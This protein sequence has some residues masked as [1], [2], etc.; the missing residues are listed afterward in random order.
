MKYFSLF[1]FV[2]L[3][4]QLNAEP[5]NLD[6]I[7]DSNKYEISLEELDSLLVPANPEQLYDSTLIALQ[8]NFKISIA[9]N[10]QNQ[11]AELLLKMANYYHK[12]GYDYLSISK[13]NA[14]EIL[15]IENDLHNILINCYTQLSRVVLEGSNYS[16]SM[17]S[18][19][20]ALRVAEKEGIDDKKDIIYFGIAKIYVAARDYKNAIHF[21]NESIK[22]SDEYDNKLCKSEALL[23]LGK[24]LLAQNKME[25]AYQI[26][27]NSLVISKNSNDSISIYNCYTKLCNYYIENENFELAHKYCDSALLVTEDFSKLNSSRTSS[28]L[29][30]KAYVY[31]CQGDYEKTLTYN[32]LAFRERK[33]AGFL[34]HIC[35]SLNNLGTTYLKL[36]NFKK[37]DDFLHKALSFAMFMENN[38]FLLLVN[39]NL[40]QLYDTTNN[41]IEA[42][43]HYKEYHKYYSLIDE[44]QNENNIDLFKTQ[45]DLEKLTRSN[46]S[47]QLS[48]AKTLQ[49]SLLLISL[50]VVSLLI[51]LLLRLSAKQKHNKQLEK[52][53]KKILSQK[54]NL[55]LLVQKMMLAEEKFK[56]IITNIDSLML[57][58][59]KDGIVTFS[60]G[61]DIFHLKKNITE[62]VG[63]SMSDVFE[64]Y[65]EITK[66]LLDALSGKSSEEIIELKNEFFQVWYSPLIDEMGNIIGAISMI[67]DKTNKIVTLRKLKESE[68]RYKKV[69]DNIT[70]GILIVNQ[71][72]KIIDL[73]AQ[74]AEIYGG[75]KEEILG[76]SRIDVS[77]KGK[78]PRTEFRRIF[79]QALKTS[80]LD[81]DL[82]FVNKKNET[83]YTE[84]SA[85]T[86][87]LEDKELQLLIFIRDVS[88]RKNKERELEDHRKHLEEKV[89]YRTRALKEKSVGLEKSQEKLESLFIDLSITSKKLKNANRELQSFSYSV[90]H[91]LKAPLRAIDGFSQAI[92][93]E[94]F[95]Q[96]DSDGKEFIKLIRENTHKMG[97]LIQ[98]LL[99]FSRIGK[100]DLSMGKINM[101]EV[102]TKSFKE[103]F[104]EDFGKETKFVL[105]DLPIICADKKQ[106]IRVVENLLANAIKFTKKTENPEIV[107]DS[108]MTGKYIVFSVRDNGIGFDMKYAEKMFGVFQ[109]LH[110]PIDYDGTGVGLAIVKKII[111]KHNGKVWIEGK[112]NVGATVYFSI[113]INNC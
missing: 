108:K 36:K 91:D 84:C 17:E 59:D 12:L 47:L 99:E 93:E 54:E 9:Q 110:S 83:I 56:T 24:I 11:Q 3:I 70:D 45:Y 46:E 100:S 20:K 63:L 98:D 61:T 90:S 58:V 43:K 101:N 55:R 44:E 10:N 35:S 13:F 50:L 21:F 64:N 42:F 79:L 97:L 15:C 94:Y 86:I 89:E 37:S 105:N 29:T 5:S 16:K 76:N 51:V 95:E 33:N 7:T 88:D 65:P 112:L 66:G 104:V 92:E 25:E 53:N 34:L 82:E 60:D 6:S 31:G 87:K 107:I 109:R 23:Q 62:F 38:Q 2:L 48:R 106:I 8:D 102:F 81:F 80:K 40:Y 67:I 39:K 28:T 49:A 69:F 73:N 68:N 75:Q 27:Q 22:M 14:A 78:N 96:L 26:F 74:I 85:T 77:I 111:N 52:N 32:V 4:F 113:P 1:F 72:G 57:S 71:Q 18:L 41:T 19:L 30:L 103:L